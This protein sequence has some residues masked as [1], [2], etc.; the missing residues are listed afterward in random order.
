MRLLKILLVL[1][2]LVVIV[3]VACLWRLPADLGYRYGEKYFGPLALTGVRGTIW[4]GHADGVSLFGNDL[5]ELDWTALKKPL[6]RGDV[7]T[8]I[9]IKGGDI[10][11]G[12]LLTRRRD[13]AVSA[14]GLRFSVPASRFEPLFDG[15]LQ[16]LGTISG[17][18]DEA[19]WWNAGLSNASGTAHWSDVGAVG[20]VEAHFTDILAEFTSQPDGS[21]SGKVRD[22]G[23]GAIA[24]L[25]HFV[26]R[27]PMLDG[28]AIL[29][30]RNGDP[31]TIETLRHIGEPLPDGTS[32][33]VLRGRMLH[34]P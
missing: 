24:V 22:D 32:R 12:G 5:G 26:L 21:V 11:I 23:R 20:E 17:V 1:V 28:E 31:Q 8:D 4:D 3:G 27:P 2:V 6:L 7:V 13:G 18:L 14:E 25:G 15:K 16:L 9:R 10:D 33:V 19:T 30:A 34:L 29:S